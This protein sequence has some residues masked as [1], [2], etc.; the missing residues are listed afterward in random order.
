MHAPG[1]KQRTVTIFVGDLPEFIALG[2]TYVDVLVDVYDE[3]VSN[4]SNA[5]DSSRPA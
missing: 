5:E 1:M 2:L 3:E 4:A